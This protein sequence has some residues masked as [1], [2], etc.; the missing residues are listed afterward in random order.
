MENDRGCLAGFQAERKQKQSQTTPIQKH[1]E[2]VKLVK[3]GEGQ[4]LRMSAS[5]RD[6]IQAT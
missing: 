1:D 3:Q 4:T 2:S 5:V 6:Q